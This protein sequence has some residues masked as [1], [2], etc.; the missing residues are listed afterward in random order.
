MSAIRL[1]LANPAQDRI[2][3]FEL[4]RQRQPPPPLDPFEALLAY[5]EKENRPITRAE[6]LAVLKRVDPAI[7]DRR[8]IALYRSKLPKRYR[9]RGRAPKSP[10]A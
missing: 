8:C 7:S 4:L 5:A 2:V 3:E 1:S 9:L 10:A 6:A